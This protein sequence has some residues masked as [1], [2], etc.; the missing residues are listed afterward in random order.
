[1]KK[2]KNTT[3]SKDAKWR[4]EFCDKTLSDEIRLARHTCVT[5]SRWLDRDSAVSRLAFS[6][7]SAFYSQTQPSKKLDIADFVRSQYYGAFWRFADYCK[8]TRVV[9]V[10]EYQRWLLKNRHAVDRWCSDS[11]YTQFLL[12]YLPTESAF[13]S[14]Y[15]SVETV[16]KLSSETTYAPAEYLRYA[17]RNRVCQAVAQ[18]QVTAWMLYNCDSGIDFVRSL[19][20]TQISMVWDYIEPES[21]NA[22]FAR[23]QTE[24]AAIRDILRVGGF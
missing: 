22:R 4:C 20:E 5:K 16:I 24:Q 21:W 2:S 8:S 13:D 3:D 10:A 14:L 17:G 23:Y 15:R 6:C 19:N 12:I 11:L 7:W 9:N 1:M 18:G